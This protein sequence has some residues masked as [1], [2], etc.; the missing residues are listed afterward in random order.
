MRAKFY[1]IRNPKYISIILYSMQ[2]II[3]LFL[4]GTELTFL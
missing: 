3:Q 1:I 4:S 2:V